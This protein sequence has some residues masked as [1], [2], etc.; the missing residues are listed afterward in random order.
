[1]RSLFILFAAVPAFAAD[2]GSRIPP[3]PPLV[4]PTYVAPVVLYAGP[5]REHIAYPKPTPAPRL[6]E[7]Y[8]VPMRYQPM[9]ARREVVPTV[10]FHAGHDCPV[11]GRSQYVIAGFNADGTHTHICAAGHAWRHR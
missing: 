8:P 4:A 5:I 9:P 3:G 7:S 10:P 2:Y 1:M 6:V 11:C